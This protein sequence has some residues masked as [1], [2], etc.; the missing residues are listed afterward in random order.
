[1]QRI[2]RRTLFKSAATAATALLLE[3][4]EP[5]AQAQ[6][7]AKPALKLRGVNLGSWLVLEKWMNPASYAGA[8]AEDEYS[9]CLELGKERATSALRKHRETW[10][11]A[12]DFKW[13]AARG[14]NAVR[15]PVGY[16]V[17][18]DNPPFIS[19]AATLDWAFMTAKEN[20]IGVLLDLHGVPGSQNGWDHSGRAGAL[21]WH[22]SKENIAHSLRVVEDL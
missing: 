2:D 6:V 4:G 1:M 17:L 22:T 8:K 11:T 5:G 10:I 7:E 13:I 19:G 21:G 9:L 14:L 12:E 18:E 3:D 16:W 20:G 15:I